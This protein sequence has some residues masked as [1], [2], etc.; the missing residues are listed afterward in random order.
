MAQRKR[1]PLIG[2]TGPAGRRGRIPWLFTRYALHRAGARAWRITT[3]NQQPIPELAGLIIGGGDDI[4]PQRYGESAE[5]SVR[6]D[7]ARDQL[8]WQMLDYAGCRNL[9]VLGIC[10]GAQLLNIFYGGNLHKDLKAVFQ[11]LVLRRTVLP[12][13]QI[14]IEPDSRLMTIMGSTETRANSLHHQA[15]NRLADGFRIAA[16]DVDNIVQA[17]EGCSERF[18][19]G[20]Q[21]HPEYLPQ[22]RAH[23]R[24]FVALAA[25]AREQLQNS[26]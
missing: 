25:A 3:S 9:P 14:Q 23:R 2:V 12:R 1:Y 4:D 20:V 7:R 22:Q 5:L 6:L 10:R 16:H 8:E 19:L 18:L 13:K 17:I 24:I 26:R 11:Q 21:W 15:V